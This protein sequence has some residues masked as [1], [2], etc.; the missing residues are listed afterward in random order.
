MPRAN[1]KVSTLGGISGPAVGGLIAA[2]SLRA[3]FFIY[4][5][6]LVVPAV[7]AAVVLRRAWLRWPWQVSARACSTWRR[8]P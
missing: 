5:G 7:I 4:G 2:W 3:P 1:P 6:L 8:R